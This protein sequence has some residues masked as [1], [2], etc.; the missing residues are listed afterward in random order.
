MYVRNIHLHIV[1]RY[2]L[3]ANAR[4]ATDSMIRLHG[5]YFP[6]DTIST[7]ATIDGLSAAMT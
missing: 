2:P 6:F 5:E 3:V 4:Y 7:L 1:L